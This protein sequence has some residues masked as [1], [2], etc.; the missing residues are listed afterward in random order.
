M[1][2]GT[3]EYD[4]ST[5]AANGVKD[6]DV[7]QAIGFQFNIKGNAGGI[8]DMALDSKVTLNAAEPKFSVVG[9]EEPPAEPSDYETGK[10]ETVE[11][12]TKVDAIKGTKTELQV[13]SITA[14]DAAK[15]SSYDVTVTVTLKDGTKKE[16]TK[17][18]SDC[19]KGFKYNNGLKDTTVT[20]AEGYFIIVKITN[21]PA[22]ATVTMSIKG[23]E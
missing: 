10:S 23:V 22:D 20:A 14:A 6:A 19:Y 5:L 21:V 2:D 8:N 7:L 16:A 18:V 3:V 1:A 13:N 17:S 12:Y 11:D 9:E 15:Y 4:L